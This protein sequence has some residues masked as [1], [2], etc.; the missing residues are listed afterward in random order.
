VMRM[1][2]HEDSDSPSD[3]TRNGAKLH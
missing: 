3:Q 2:L 1:W